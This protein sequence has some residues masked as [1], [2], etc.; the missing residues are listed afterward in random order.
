M[1]LKDKD[2]QLKNF[3]HQH[4]G[5][6]IEHD[7]KRNSHLLYTLK[8]YLDHNGSKK[9]AAD[10]LYIARQSL[11]YRL[12]KLQELLGDGFLTT[13]NQLTLQ[14]ALKACQL[15]YPELLTSRG[16]NTKK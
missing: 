1:N 11:Y 8:V 5:P 3:I 12:E 2:Q 16:E 9:A 15:I 13:E 10:H 4:L 7:Q 14:T 6:V